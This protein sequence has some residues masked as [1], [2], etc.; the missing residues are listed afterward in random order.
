MGVSTDGILAYG[1]DLSKGDEGYAVKVPW[2]K[3]TD[4]DYEEPEDSEDIED[5]ED[6]DIEAWWAEV[7]G[8]SSK[9]LWKQYY[10]WEAENKTGDYIK[11]NDLVDRYEKLHPE[12]RV[13]LDKYYEDKKATD[14]TC[15]VEIVQHCSYEYP[16]YI[17]AAKGQHW[18]AWRGH[19]VEIES[20]N[21]DEAARVRLKEFCRV[22]DIEFEP[23]WI[24]A[25]MWG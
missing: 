11:D 20:L 6:N 7:N 2:A 23:K 25:S 24:L 1:I 5:E 12:W 15:P 10:A 19:P 4:P 16:M 3:H 22:Y 8:V 21:V 18:N 9:E 17:L 14:E 13:A